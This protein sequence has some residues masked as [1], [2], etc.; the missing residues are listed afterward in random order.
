MKVKTAVKAG[1]DNNG[2]GN[3]SLGRENTNTGNAGVVITLPPP[4]A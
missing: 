1:Q 2:V 4:P 3:I